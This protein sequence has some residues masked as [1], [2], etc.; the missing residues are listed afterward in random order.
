[1]CSK[2]KQ[3]FVHSPLLFNILLVFI[4]ITQRQGKEVK[5]II[6]GKEGETLSF[7]YDTIMYIAISL[8]FPL[9]LPDITG[10]SKWI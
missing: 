8:E 2:K 4:P 7:S 3:G 10:D 5:C 1:M 9:K 6:F